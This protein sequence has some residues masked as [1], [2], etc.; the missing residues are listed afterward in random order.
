MNETA[1]DHQHAHQRAHL[2]APAKGPEHTPWTVVHDFA[3]DV[4]GA[5]RVT[6]ALANEVLD[7]APV[8]TLGGEQGLLDDLGIDDVT[9]AYPRLFRRDSYRRASLLLPAMLRA[10]APVE[11]HVLASSYAFSH[12][13]RAT[14]RKVVYCHSPLRQA[15]S[16]EQMYLD[17]LPRA[18]H[19]AAR[20][21]LRALR[22]SDRRAADTATDYVANST[23]VAARLER[24]YGIEAAAVAYPPPHE[25]FTRGPDERGG[26]Y[27]W[28]GRIVEPYKKLTP[29]IEAFR[30]LDREL[31]VAGDGRDAARLRATAPPNVTFIGAVGTERL[32]AEYRRARALLFPSE[33]DF[34]LVP[35]EA[36]SCGTPVIALARGGATETV[37]DGTSGVLF[38]ESDPATI[39]AAVRRFESLDLDEDAVEAQGRRFGREQFVRT[40]RQVLA[41]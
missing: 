39:T 34:G 21:P 12:H 13:V 35:V 8:V 22:A 38:D 40:V 41:S 28:A 2:P 16:G 37:L 15:W 27:L 18:T 10:A 9:I 20:L 23:V 31:V 14:G 1:L 33:D 24:F 11:G 29:V 6:A 19:R 26:H 30:H 32:A 5:E 7:G 17:R 3:F 36:M 4:G 25:A